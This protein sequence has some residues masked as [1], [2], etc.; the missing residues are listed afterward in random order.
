[1]I[2]LVGKTNSG[3][4]TIRDELVKLGFDKV[5]SYT[6]RPMRTGEQQDVEYHFIN[7]EK[8]LDKD[9]FNRRD[10]TVANGDTWHYGFD[11]ADFG[12]NS[13]IIVDPVH[14]I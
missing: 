5:I 1:M 7:E 9:I 3:K 10:Y 13:C 8:F 6:T 12:D 11:I 4:S 14:S 2:V